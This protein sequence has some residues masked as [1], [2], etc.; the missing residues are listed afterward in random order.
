MGFALKSGLH[1]IPCVGEQLEE[2]E[3][4]KTNEVVFRQTK[5]IGGMYCKI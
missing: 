4:G 5:V 1:V 3:A 2:R